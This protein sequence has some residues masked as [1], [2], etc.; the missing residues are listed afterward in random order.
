MAPRH[1]QIALIVILITSGTGCLAYA[2]RPT[3]VPTPERRAVGT[4]RVTL[5]D[6]PQYDL[7]NAYQQGDSLIGFTR[8]PP[9]RR[10]AVAIPAVIKLES[11]GMSWRS[12]G[13]RLGLVLM[14]FGGFLALIGGGGGP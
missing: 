13:K 10:V 6:G 9:S 12:F 8:Q 3:P 14:V 11:Y 2:A 5:A 4:V 1:W 7:K